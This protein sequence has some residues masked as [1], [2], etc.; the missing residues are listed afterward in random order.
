MS[1]SIGKTWSNLSTHRK[2]F[3]SHHMGAEALAGA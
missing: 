1:T 3:R 2:Y